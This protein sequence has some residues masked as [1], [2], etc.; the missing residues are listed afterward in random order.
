MKVDGTQYRSIWRD[1][2]AGEVRI[3]DQRWLPHDFRIATLHGLEDFATAIRD[4]WVRGAPLIGA[5]AAHGVAAEMARDASDAHLDHV[6][7]VLNATRPTA[8]NLAWALDRCRNAL[9]AL[10]VA[11]RP[12][13]ALRLALAIAD[14]DVEIN[15]RIGDHGLTLPSPAIDWTVADR[16]RGIPIEDRPGAEVSHVQG[17]DARGAIAQVQVTPNGSPTANPAFDVT[18]AR[19]VTGL[20]TERGICAASRA[21][22]AGLFPDLCS[23]ESRTS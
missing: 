11:D 18:P 6:H 13:A 17:R 1:E 15:R 3:I 5:T 23:A 7:G 8:I 12:A 4:M 10:P 14:E 22:L 20:I 2:T 19:L 21:G 16:L 9:R